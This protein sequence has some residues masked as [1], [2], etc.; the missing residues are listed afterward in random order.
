MGLIN[1]TYP[2]F[3]YCCC[4]MSYHFTYTM[5]GSND[6]TRGGILDFEDLDGEVNSVDF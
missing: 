5:L 3:C 2:P 1:V 6:V 4:F